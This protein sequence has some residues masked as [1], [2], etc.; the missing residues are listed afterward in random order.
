LGF[1]AAGVI[2]LGVVDVC[3][4]DEASTKK[5]ASLFTSIRNLFL[6]STAEARMHGRI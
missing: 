5:H 3:D 2:V 6:I 1:G 4:G